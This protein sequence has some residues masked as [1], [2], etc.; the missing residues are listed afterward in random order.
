MTRSSR[1]GKSLTGQ[2]LALGATNSGLYGGGLALAPTPPTALGLPRTG[3]RQQRR[4]RARP[5]L[6]PLQHGAAPPLWP[7]PRLLHRFDPQPQRRLPLLRRRERDTARGARRQPQR[8]GARAGQRRAD[9][10]Q[11]PHARHRRPPPAHR[12]PLGERRRPPT[13]S[14]K[15]APCGSATARR[16]TAARSSTSAA[17]A[18]RPSPR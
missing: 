8:P 6:R 4:R 15:S 1:R 18:A 12:P 2:A 13:R 10:D 9:R 17:A 14:Q 11:P 3:L 5:R 16:S 7:G